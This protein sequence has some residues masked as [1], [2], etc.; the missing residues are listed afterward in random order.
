MQARLPA[1]GHTPSA[2]G[3]KEEELAG[4]GKLVGFTE[5]GYSAQS[6]PR[7]DQL[8]KRVAVALALM[9]LLALG[10]CGDNEDS[11]A[12]EGS[13]AASP[14]EAEASVSFT[15]PEDGDTVAN[16]VKVK[17]EAEGFTIEPASSGVREGAGHLHIM[18]DTECVPEGEVIPNDETH[19]HYGMGQT[20]AE[21][22]L[23]PGKH[24]LCLQAADGAHVA[25]PITSEI[26]IT[27]E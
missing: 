16:P 20:E 17:M 23:A 19:K 15:S 6:K 10:A 27:V 12:L 7:R 21:L 22:T 1:L 9:C 13:P 26:S 25:L 14:E 2:L 3:R 18:V 5:M 11:G 24:D 8:M 4:S